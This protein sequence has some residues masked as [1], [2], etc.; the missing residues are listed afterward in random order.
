MGMKARKPPRRKTGNK[1]NLL[2]IPTALLRTIA[3]LP[4]EL[5]G[6]TVSGTVRYDGVMSVKA[7][8]F[9]FG[10]PASYRTALG[11]LHRRSRIAEITLE[12]ASGSW[13]EAGRLAGLLPGLGSAVTEAVFDLD[14]TGPK[15]KSTLR[16]SFN[17]KSIPLLIAKGREVSV[18]NKD[19]TKADDYVDLKQAEAV[20][21]YTMLA[22]P[23]AALI[24]RDIV[25]RDDRNL[26]QHPDPDDPK[27]IQIFLSHRPPGIIDRDRHVSKL[28]GLHFYEDKTSWLVPTAAHGRG[29]IIELEGQEVVQVI[30]D[31]H[32]VLVPMTSC[33]NGISSA[34]IFN[35]ILEGVHDRLGSPEA[36]DGDDT[37]DAEGYGDFL[38]E[39]IVETRKERREEFSE[40]QARVRRL[41]EELGQELRKLAD[42]RAQIRG[43]EESE[44][45]RTAIERAESDFERLGGNPLVKRIMSVDDGLHIETTDVALVHEGRRY[46]LGEFT[47]RID[48]KGRVEVWN[49]NPRHP[50]GHHHPHIDKE[51][52][53]CFGNVTLAISKYAGAYRL[54]EAAELTLRW[55]RNYS[56]ETT[57]IPIEEWPSEPTHEGKE[58]S[59]V[60]ETQPLGTAQDLRA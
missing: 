3:T 42:L 53:A 40:A 21:A 32:Y 24:G 10:D 18:T 6:E 37:L 44:E 43:L 9:S 19:E 34:V 16:E 29:K 7:I 8:V 11:L 58:V 5:S 4:E 14:W 56:P 1:T 39:Q 31:N 33:F 36:E 27:R 2:A 38:L 35:K 13:Q 57:L 46:R 50:K 54:I 60:H 23:L 25:L 48:R 51:S 47:I 41:Q 20:K 52:L 59:S 15:V 28:F 45:T 49:E 55:L 30:G 22:K 17:G 26:F 12:I